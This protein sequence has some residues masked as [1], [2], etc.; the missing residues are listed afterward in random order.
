MLCNGICC[1]SA[2]ALEIRQIKDRDVLD[3]KD[4][5]ERGNP[6][7]C[8]LLRIAGGRIDGRF[9]GPEG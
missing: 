4:V 7:L 9:F 8:F 3:E 1:L 6:V 2:G 5:I